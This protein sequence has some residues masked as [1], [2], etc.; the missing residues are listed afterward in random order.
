[1]RP[2]YLGSALAFA[3]ILAVALVGLASVV[4]GSE[5]AP[6]STLDPAAFRPV[7]IADPVADATPPGR[8][9]ELPSAAPSLEPSA[10]PSPS[11]SPSPTPKPTLRPTPKPTPRPTPKPTP[12]PTPVPAPTV[13]SAKAYALSVLGASQYACLDAIATHES[14]WNTYAVSPSTG[15]YGIP[16]ALPGD[17]MATV[18][19]DWRTDPLTQV[20]WMIGYVRDA[21]GSACG[22]WSFWQMNS[23][24]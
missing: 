17:K 21:Y 1:M 11:P 23:W 9:D 19:A 14:N 2:I 13:A 7:A 6:P 15:A 5:P 10:A 22:A 16:Q 18:G 12:K 3:I 8:R 20:R 4:T 24:Y